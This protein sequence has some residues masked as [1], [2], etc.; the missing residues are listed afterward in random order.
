MRA[1]ETVLK[2]VCS[3]LG[4]EPER[5]GLVTSS[6]TGRRLVTTRLDRTKALREH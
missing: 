2:A 3:G 5:A 1:E 4:N 6:T